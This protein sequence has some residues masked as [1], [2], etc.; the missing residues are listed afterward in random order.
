MLRIEKLSRN[1]T[2]E[3][4]TA[5]LNLSHPFPLKKGQKMIASNVSEA[6]ENATANTLINHATNANEPTLCYKKVP[7]KHRNGIYAIIH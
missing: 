3:K 4:K 6:E 7:R 1:Q 5:V 2:T